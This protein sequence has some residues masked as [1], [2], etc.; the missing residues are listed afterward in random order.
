MTDRSRTQNTLRQARGK[1]LWPTRPQPNK[2]EHRASKCARPT[3]QCNNDCEQERQWA[4]GRQPHAQTH[5]LR[6]AKT[7]TDAQARHRR[8]TTRPTH[9]RTQRKL[10]RSPC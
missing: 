3:W 10:T 4:R 6:N 5:G 7:A 1:Q 9:G 2:T 8:P